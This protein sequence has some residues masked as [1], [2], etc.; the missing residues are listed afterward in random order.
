MSAFTVGQEVIYTRRVTNRKTQAKYIG[1]IIT[2]HAKKSLVQFMVDGK[3][4]A[5]LLANK[6]LRLYVETENE[7]QAN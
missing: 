3:P 1:T 4:I 2:A 5:R 6:N 7:R